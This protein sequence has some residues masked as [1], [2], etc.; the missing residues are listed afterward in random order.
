MMNDLYKNEWRFY[1]NFFMP[2]TKL[3]EKTRLGSRY[4]KK[5]DTPKTP[6][7]RILEEPSIPQ[8]I[9][10]KLTEIY[11]TLDPFLLKKNI[12]LKLKRIV[13]AIK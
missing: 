6:Y 3:V 11:N 13:H 1:Q 2:A 5:Y 12:Q 7:Q 10:D 9:K 8:K 4:R